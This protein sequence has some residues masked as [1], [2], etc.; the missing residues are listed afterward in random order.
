MERKT[1]ALEKDL[2]LTGEDFAAMRTPPSQE[3]WDLAAYLD[4]LE[5][6]EAFRTRKTAVKVYREPFRL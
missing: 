3:P 4:F 1:L 6:I 2:P 5:E